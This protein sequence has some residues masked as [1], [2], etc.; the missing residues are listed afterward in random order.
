I[1]TVSYA[2]RIARGKQAH[3]ALRRF[4]IARANGDK[5]AMA[6]AQQALQADYPYFGY[7]YFD[8]VD[9]AIPPVGV[10]F[11]SFRIMVIL[12]SYFLLFYVLVLIGVYYREW[13]YRAR[14]MQVVAIL[15]VPLMWVCSEAGWI[16]AEVGRQ[17]W[18]VQ[19]LLPTRAAISS[20]PASSVITTFWLFAGIFTILLIAEV[21]IMMHQISIRSSQDLETA[22]TY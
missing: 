9:E 4:D 12:G 18:T 14:W 16:V 19:D 1:N 8:S 22:N 17:P 13:L 6:A 5:T 15:S 20:L 11:Y 21:S 2:E 7:G 10:T 3:E